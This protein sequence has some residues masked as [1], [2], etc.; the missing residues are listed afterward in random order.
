MLIFVI[1]VWQLPVCRNKKNCDNCAASLS[2]N[3]DN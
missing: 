3:V 1:I 2:V